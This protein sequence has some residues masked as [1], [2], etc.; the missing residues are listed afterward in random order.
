M[1]SLYESILSSNN[2]S[3]LSKVKDNL[4]YC[5]DVKEFGKLWTKLGLDV[6]KCHWGY[7]SGGGYL[8]NKDLNCNRIFCMTT[9]DPK[10]YPCM[11]IY[12]D[13]KEWPEKFDVEK[14]V[15]IVAKT[16]NMTYDYN[17]GGWYELKFK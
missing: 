10:K 7:T 6:D 1:K 13:P 3:I 4:N 8:Y 14:Y 2:A 11:F 5:N 9:T 17:E 16:L 12:D 15:K